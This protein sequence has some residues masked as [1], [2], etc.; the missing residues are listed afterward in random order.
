MNSEKVA[1]V[2]MG[3]IFPQSPDPDSLWSVVANG[4]NTSDEPP[5]GRW[6]LSTEDT[7]SPEVPSPDK[8]CSRRACLI[9]YIPLDIEGSHGSGLNV[10]SDLVSQLD[11]LFHLALYAGR[12]A[13]EDTKT[14]QIDRSRTGVIIGNIALPTE[15]SS[16]M[17]R[18]FLG[19]TFE[20]KLLGRPARRKR[21][22][23]PLNRYVTGLP[24]GVLA[25]A[26]GLG[27]G[28]YTLDAACASSLYALKLAADELL[29]G[30]AVAM[31]TGGISRP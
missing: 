9:E 8:V 19:W 15:T 11:P 21:R 24:A 2:G 27:G 4:I 31:L 5:P 16:A 13:W 7:Y 26:L 30:R 17:A 12:Q 1:I 18:E 28:S 29:A 25:K 6:L 23:H 20:E 14:Q 10:D 22:T 3:C